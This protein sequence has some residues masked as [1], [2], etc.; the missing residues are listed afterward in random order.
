MNPWLALALI[1]AAWFAFFW[2]WTRGMVPDENAGPMVRNPHTDFEPSP[3][4]LNPANPY[5]LLSPF[6]FFR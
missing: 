2:W 6:S 3:M 5:S 1:F 4:S